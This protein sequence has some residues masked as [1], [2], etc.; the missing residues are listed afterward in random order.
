MLPLKSK[1]FLKMKRFPHVL[2]NIQRTTTIMIVKNAKRLSQTGTLSVPK[3]TFCCIMFYE[4]QSN[5]T[6]KSLFLKYIC[7][8]DKFFRKTVSRHRKFINVSKKTKS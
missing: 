2:T 4:L 8:D 7:N 6:T 5:K 3:C 1:S